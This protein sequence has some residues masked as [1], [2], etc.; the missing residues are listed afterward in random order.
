MGSRFSDWGRRQHSE[1][2]GESGKHHPAVCLQKKKEK[3]KKKHGRPSGLGFMIL[4][5]QKRAQR[6]WRVPGR[7]RARPLTHGGDHAR[8]VVGS[9]GQAGRRVHGRGRGQHV[10]GVAEGRDVAEGRHVSGQGRGVEG[11]ALGEVLQRVVHL[12]AFFGFAGHFPVSGLDAFFLHRQG[13]VNL[14]KHRF[15]FFFSLF[16]CWF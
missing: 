15:F 8:R 10:A 1:L 11:A 7:R 16:F 3:K 5:L 12:F 13:S 9:E 6:G 14:N 4:L 2:L